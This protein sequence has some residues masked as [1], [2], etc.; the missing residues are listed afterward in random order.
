MNV[1][2]R[3]F[4]A[5]CSL[6][7]V[8]AVSV[9]LLSGFLPNV[10]GSYEDQRFLFVLFSGALTL[11]GTVVSLSKRTISL[12][13]L[14]FVLS[15]SIAL[16]AAFLLLS[17]PFIGQPHGMVEP[18]MY[19]FFFIVIIL[20]GSSLSC[21]GN[22]P[23]FSLFLIYATAVGC[24]VYGA[25]SINVYIFAISDGTTKLVGLIPWAFVNIR[26][27]SHIATWFMPLLPLAILLGPLKKHRLWR[28]CVFIGGGLWW[29]IVFMSAARGSAISVAFGCVVAV[30]FFGRAAFSWV[31]AFLSILL[32]GVAF[33]VV[34]SVAI[35]SFLFDEVTVRSVGVGSSG[36]LP[37][38]IEAF[39]MSIQNFPFGM[40]P[41]SWLTHE[42]FS[43][44]YLDNRRL[45][46]PHNM[47]LMWAAEYG[48]MLIG[49]LVVVLIQVVRYLLKL[50][51]KALG[52]YTAEHS[53][54]VT[55]Y[56][57]SVC[58][59]LLHAAVSAVFLAPGSMLVGMFILIGFWGLILRESEDSHQADVVV[60]LFH[61]RKL[62]IFSLAFIVLVAWLAWF[63]EVWSYY[64]AM[65]ED[66]LTFYD[67]VGEN[68]FPRFWFHGNY[69]R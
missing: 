13:S 52:S 16:A 62:V 38:F 45:G 33:W 42:A 63:A 22:S 32:V 40:G 29:W 18:G 19:A 48:W 54:L 31:R 5:L 46:H 9:V 34:L 61:K 51:S 67:E 58:G 3:L 43:D 12:K 37:L 53:L 50:R 21:S 20:A 49:F 35:P 44:V 26:Y 28:N 7:F 60:D 39:Q 47:Y 55:G 65:R 64:Q 23:D 27:W 8:L 17:F 1:T 56:T 15:P 59:A 25:M 66:E 69:P 30:L 2:I 68:T 11:A 24:F 6:A 14:A 10:F 4:P 41:Q 57:A 36:R